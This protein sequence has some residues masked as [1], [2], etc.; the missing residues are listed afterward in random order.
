MYIDQRSENPRKETTKSFK[1]NI[2]SL[3]VLLIL[4]T[5]FHISEKRSTSVLPRTLC[6]NVLLTDDMIPVNACRDFSLIS[7][8][9]KSKG[10]EYIYCTQFN[11]VKGCFPNAN[12]FG[13]I[14]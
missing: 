5:E 1:K 3:V 12:V 4:H 2:N 9:N 7:V 6:G 14:F 11:N 8:I 13:K 10:I